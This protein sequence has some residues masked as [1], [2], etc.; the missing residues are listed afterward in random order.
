M[1]YGGEFGVHKLVHTLDEN[2]RGPSVSY[3]SVESDACLV[4]G[5]HFVGC[6]Q[7]TDFGGVGVVG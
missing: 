3:T 2:I 6:L 7:C 5:M 4:P 1:Y